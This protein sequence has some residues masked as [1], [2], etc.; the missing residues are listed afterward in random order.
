MNEK[1]IEIKI[2][3]QKFK[4]TDEQLKYLLSKEDNW[5]L[6]LEE[7]STAFAKINLKKLEE[8]TNIQKDIDI[9]IIC[10]I[11]KIDNK[12]YSLKINPFQF[13]I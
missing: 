6:P 4:I 2:Y 13:L 12:L 1:E 8:I 3:N 9:N 5:I 11:D 10:E 7:N